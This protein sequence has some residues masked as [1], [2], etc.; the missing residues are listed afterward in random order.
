MDSHG[1]HETG[2]EPYFYSNY[3]WK[4]LRGYEKGRREVMKVIERTRPPFGSQGSG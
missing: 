1:M 3:I 4:E 2:D